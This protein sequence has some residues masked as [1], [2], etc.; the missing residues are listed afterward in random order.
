[1]AKGKSPRNP[2]SWKAQ[3]EFCLLW[4]RFPFFFLAAGKFAQNPIGRQPPAPAGIAG[5]L[6]SV[7][8]FG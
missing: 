5:G 8:Q 6:D 3:V 1:M 7:T 2:M 4:R